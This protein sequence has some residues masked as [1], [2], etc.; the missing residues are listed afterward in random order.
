MCFKSAVPYMGPKGLACTSYRVLFGLV[1]QASDTKDG[2]S[3]IMESLSSM[4]E[5]DQQVVIP[6]DMPTI[7]PCA[8]HQE[9]CISTHA[10]AM[11]CIG[12]CFHTSK[13]S[14]T[15]LCCSALRPVHGLLALEDVD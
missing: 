5:G 13:S 9:L 11:L 7:W 2:G 15:M 12:N 1:Q 6:F 4:D 3:K 8:A 14:L 10:A